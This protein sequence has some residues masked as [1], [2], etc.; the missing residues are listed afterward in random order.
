MRKLIA[1][2]L[3]VLQFAFCAFVAGKNVLDEKERKQHLANA[4]AYGEKVLLRLEGFQ[5][6]ETEDREWQLLSLSVTGYDR[7]YEQ[8]ELIPFAADG[9][10]YYVI[11]THAGNALTV[12]AG[13]IDR[14]GTY[15]SACYGTFI[16]DQTAAAAAFGEDRAA[17]NV[18]SDETWGRW[19]GDFGWGIEV[20]GRAAE[21]A[22]SAIIYD[23]ELYLTGLVVNGQQIP[24]IESVE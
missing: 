20:G 23:N 5:I 18:P 21:V 9:D 22:V 12:R 13:P 16:L 19:Y 14:A 10:G 11:D 4:R 3:A 8:D 1:I 24:I 17:D 7:F 2:V 15:E 6:S